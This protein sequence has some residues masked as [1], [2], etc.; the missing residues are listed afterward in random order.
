MAMSNNIF[1]LITNIY[2]YIYKV[3]I[4]KWS[5]MVRQNRPVPK[6]SILIDKS[7]R[8][9]KQYSYAYNFSKM[10][11][12]FA[13]YLFWGGLPSRYNISSSLMFLHQ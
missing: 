8:T 11:A 1:L 2:I 7:T 3:V 9:P 6:Y 12:A 10:K 5:K 13:F 4:L